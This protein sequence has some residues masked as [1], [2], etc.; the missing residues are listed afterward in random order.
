MRLVVKVK[1]KIILDLGKH[2]KDVTIQS[3]GPNVMH[4]KLSE[5]RAFSDSDIKYII[6]TI[7]EYA[8][9]REDIEK[10]VDKLEGDKANVLNIL[11]GKKHRLVDIRPV[12]CKIKLE[13]KI[14]HYIDYEG[15]EEEPYYAAFLNYDPSDDNTLFKSN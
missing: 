2:D 12:D 11:K 3:I 6:S 9:F 14:D 4:F 10:Y 5:V 7:P 15:E 8:S 1:H 13:T